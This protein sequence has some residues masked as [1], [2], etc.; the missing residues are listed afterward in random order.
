[1][2]FFVMLIAQ[3]LWLAGVVCGQVAVESKPVRAVVAEDAEVHGKYLILAK[4]A[5]V[6]IRPA[7][8]LTYDGIGNATAAV[9]ASD[10]KRQPVPVEQVGEARYLV[11]GV[12]KIWVRMTLI[13]FDEKRFEIS[14]TTV[15]IGETEPEPPPEP[16]TPDVPEDEFGN[17]GQRVANWA[18]GVENPKDFGQVYADGA[19]TLRTSPGATID[20]VAL[21]MRESFQSLDG[22][23]QFVPV[24]KKVQTDL[25]GRW[26]LSRGVLADYYDAISRGFGL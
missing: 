16:D 5:E 20:S 18:I 24:A 6:T 8:M 23:A 2:R 13:D 10:I 7:A 21:S 26:P 14:E 11:L 1:M 25:E 4:D 22:Y 3:L 19:K 12:G 17:I 9:E 15:D